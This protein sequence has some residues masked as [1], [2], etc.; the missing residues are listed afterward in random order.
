MSTA[1]ATTDVPKATAGLSDKELMGLLDRL[2]AE[3]GGQELSLERLLWKAES[4][5]KFPVTG[6]ILD[7]V[8]MPK[9]DRK[10]NPDW[11]AFIV[12]TTYETRGVN[13]NKEV[14]KIA[15]GSEVV[16]PANYQLAANLARFALDPD[17]I[18]E[19]AIQATER[20]DIGGGKK[21][22]GFRVVKFPD[23]VKKRVGLDRLP[24]AVAKA[25]PPHDPETGEVHDN[26]AAAS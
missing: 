9:A 24:E 18:H 1:K 7:C 20:S 15:A 6:Y 11:K 2:I 8:D 19:I 3:R 12:R 21:M 13:R 14:V 22:W 10:D 23:G 17:Y 5:G 25:L 4:C 16:V 26:A